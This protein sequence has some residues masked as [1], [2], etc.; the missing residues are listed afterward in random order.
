MTQE[1]FGQL[2]EHLKLLRPTFDQFCSVSGYRYV[3]PRS[4]G[5]YPR[6]RIEK[7][8]DFTRWFDLWM[9]LDNDGNRYQSFFEDVP[10]ELAAGG[11]SILT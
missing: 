4:I 7:L 9:E 10:Y 11:E 2:R 1:Q 5:M 6:I 3:D 8:G